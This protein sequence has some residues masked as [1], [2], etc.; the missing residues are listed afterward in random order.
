MYIYIKFERD[1]WKFELEINRLIPVPHFKRNYLCETWLPDQRKPQN[2]SIPNARKCI[3]YFLPSIILLK[4][5]IHS[6][7][8]CTFC[9]ALARTSGLSWVTYVPQYLAT[10]DILTKSL[11]EN[12]PSLVCRE[13]KKISSTLESPVH[14][15]E[16][17]P[18]KHRPSI[19][20]N[21][22]ILNMERD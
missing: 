15:T 3:L 14:A 8:K 11:P 2:N 10:L 20:S 13:C 19:I 5:F 16:Q 1:K 9:Q 6:Y 22:R 12:I 4:A 18:N 21:K 17:V 7:W